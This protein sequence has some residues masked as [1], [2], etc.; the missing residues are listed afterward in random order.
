MCILSIIIPSYKDP[1]LNKTI[2]SILLNSELGN[3]L[4]I[5]CVLDGYWQT[6][7]DDPRVKVI[8]LGGNR[9]MRGAIN[10]GV[11]VS[12]GEYLMRTDEHCMFGK[13]FDRILLETIEDNW[14]VCPRRFFLDPVKWKVM[15][16]EPVDYCDLI[17][18]DKGG[19]RKFS[20]VTNTKFA[21][22][23]KDLM[24]DETEAIQGSMWVMKRTWWDK[25]I[26]ELDTET[27]GPLYFD[28][29][30]MVFKTWQ[31][32][33]KLMVN[34]NTWY[35]HKHRDFPRTHSNGTKENPSN[36]EKCFATSIK[37]WQPYYEQRFKRNIHHK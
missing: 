11:L 20:G 36:N 24:I 15:D 35:A 18:A 37:I 22:E 14:I 12:T 16:I 9:G 21:E 27:Y 8:H 28:S 31:A 30:E 3:D 10:A 29:H 33:G 6:I 19:V 7:I 34:K 23:R 13:G 4:E 25:V 2:E 1:L 17:I 32:G 5:I 26:G